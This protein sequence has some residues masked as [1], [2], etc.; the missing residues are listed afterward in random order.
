LYFIL[1]LNSKIKGG[2]KCISEYVAQCTTG[3]SQ[4]S[5]GKML[6][7]F[8]NHLDNRC[9]KPDNRH[10]FIEHVKCFNPREKMQPLNECDDKHIAMMLLI[11]DLGKD[12]RRS[13]LCCS[14]HK[15]HE[16]IVTKSKNIC[17]EGS[18]Q[19]WDDIIQEVVSFLKFIL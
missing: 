14:F 15:F 2:I 16:C 8:G 19:Y 7:D 17:G 5:L 18:S 10:E 13:A 3:L 12:D 4:K 6:A 11:K 1:W 9:S